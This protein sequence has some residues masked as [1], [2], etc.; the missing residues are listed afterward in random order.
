MSCCHI[1]HLGIYDS[2]AKKGEETLGRT[3]GQLHSR[4]HDLC[5]MGVATSE[6][7]T[8]MAGMQEWIVSLSLSPRQHDTCPLLL[9]QLFSGWTFSPTQLQLGGTQWE[10]H[11]SHIKTLKLFTDACSLI[12]TM[13]T[14]LPSKGRLAFCR[15]VPVIPAAGYWGH[16]F[17]SDHENSP[18][19]FRVSSDG[20]RDT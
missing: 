15:A 2:E 6:T 14:N 8:L 11:S 5:W 10:K 4:A 17:Y 3:P 13:F 1:S 19:T 7:C 9:E 16:Q 20:P 12:T 18:Q